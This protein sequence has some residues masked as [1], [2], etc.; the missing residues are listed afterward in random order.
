MSYLEAITSA[1]VIVLDIIMSSPEDGG[2]PKELATSSTAGMEIFRAIRERRKEVPIVAFSAT[3]NV[4]I[5]EALREDPHTT[6]ISKWES[7]SLKELIHIVLKAGR[8]D[9]A[10]LPLRPFIVH[11]HDETTMR[12]L[13]DY[14]QN[15]LALPEP[16]ILRQ[17]PNGGRTLI[18][19]F[20]ETALGA[21]FVFVLLTPDD[22]MAQDSDSDDL[23]RR[24]RQ[25]V[26]LEIGYFLGSL[27]RKSG[28]ILFLYKKPP[29]D[30]PSDISGIVYIDIS[31]GVEAA[32]E[33]IR[34]E[35]NHAKY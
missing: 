28:R 1:D 22:K 33:K 35:V 29:L 8:L 34:Q 18:E 19:K 31:S 3:Q 23:K 4:V 27:G 7:P 17:E 15:K 13:K 20:E 11:G 12:E 6:F 32:G 24:A 25:N 9:E 2:S 16:I 5:R 21:S 30:L 26:I 10:T 14:L